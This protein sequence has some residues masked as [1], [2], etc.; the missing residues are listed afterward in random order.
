MS[1]KHQQEADAKKKINKLLS[2]FDFKEKPLIRQM[3]GEILKLGKESTDKNDLKL[4]LTTIHELRQSF[5]VFFPF[6]DIRKVCMFGSARTKPSNPNYTLAE[7]TARSLTQK[8]LML[9]TGAGGGIME[10]GNKGAEVNMSFGVNIILPFEQSANEYIAHDSKLI[11]YKYFFNRKLT[12]IKESDAIV[13]FPGG[14]GTHDEAFEVLTLIQT[15]RC[16]PRPVLLMSDANSDYWEMWASFVKK[17]LMKKAY[18]SDQDLK[19]FKIVKDPEEATEYILQ[20]YNVFHSIRY[21][22][23]VTL[24]RIN[25]PISA[26]ALKKIKKDFKGLLESGDFEIWSSP[27]LK[28]DKEKYKDKH[29]LVFHFDRL[30]FGLLYDLIHFLNTQA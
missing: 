9:I 23:D 21:I 11:D 6:R 2:D 4:I 28:V 20:F 22:D 16:S 5:K 19:L 18:I 24:I 14:F 30:S 10:A 15:G 3:I 8:G 26:P 7:E 27:N 17:Q 25:N 13:L 12:F 1:T 29:R